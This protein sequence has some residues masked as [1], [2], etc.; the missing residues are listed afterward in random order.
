MIFVTVGT[1]EQPFDRLV[2]TVDELKRDGKITEDVIIQTGFC[3]YEPKYCTWEKTFTNAEMEERVRKARIVITH[4]GPSSFMMPLS[5]GKIPVVVP[6]QHD[7][8]EHVNDHQVK[9]CEAVNEKYHCLLLVEDIGELE[10]VLEN[11]DALS[12]PLLE[13]MKKQDSSAEI[14][15][16]HAFVSE[17]IKLADA[18]WEEKKSKSRRHRKS[19]DN[20]KKGGSAKET[21][22]KDGPKICL[23]GSSGGH[24]RHL[25]LLKDYWQQHDRFWVTFDKADAK[26]LLGGEKVI[27][28]YY[29]TNR[30]LKALIINTR[31]AWKVL[32]KEKPDILIS[33]GAAVAVPFFYLGKLFGMKTM[34][35]EV[36]DRMDSPTL[37]GKMVYPVTDCFIVQWE[38]MKKVYKKAINLE[39]IY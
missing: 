14:G 23:V 34:Y 28:C 15:H 31:L 16:N 5:M 24:L 26:G 35:V 30:S 25:Y 12:R 3:T 29:P 13:D 19:A 36:F 17:F 7:L 4:G 33:S 1:H 20:T 11:Y 38:S 22:A 39:S 37:T 18:C 9:F 27:G 10:G 8:G 2:R 21:D 6:R 32:R